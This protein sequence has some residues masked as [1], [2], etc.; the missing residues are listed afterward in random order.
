M[1][2]MED[3]T[4]FFYNINCDD[5]KFTNS[6]KGTYL[7]LQ[8]NFKCE[9]YVEKGVLMNPETLAFRVTTCPAVLIHQTNICLPNLAM[10]FDPFYLINS[11]VSHRQ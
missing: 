6:F 3:N 5:C 1:L 11:A 10:P 7:F 8:I 4:V 9:V 2:Q